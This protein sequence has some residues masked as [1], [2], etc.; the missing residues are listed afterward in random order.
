MP[1][2]AS[3][4][5]KKAGLCATWPAPQP[6]TAPAPLQGSCGPLPFAKPPVPRPGSKAKR[7][8]SAIGAIVG[9]RCHK[10]ALRCL[11]SADPASCCSDFCSFHDLSDKNS[12]LLH[13]FCVKLQAQI[14]LPGSPHQIAAKRAPKAL[15][16]NR[17]SPVSRQRGQS[18]TP[19]LDR[20]PQS[21][22]QQPAQS[23]RLTYR[24]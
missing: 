5:P 16:I 6:P 14:L 10:S 15:P 3:R 2:R 7:L 12:M 4:F 19:W 11:A 9:A 8:C 1:I 23:S 24:S 18:P 21:P 13:I 20:S 22:A 17:R